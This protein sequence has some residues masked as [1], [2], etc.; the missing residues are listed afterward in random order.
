MKLMSDAIEII[1]LE[2]KATHLIFRCCLFCS[3]YRYCKDLWPQSL[4]YFDECVSFYIRS[5]FGNSGLLELVE[6]LLEDFLVAIDDSGCAAWV[7]DK[8]LVRVNR[9]YESI[10]ENLSYL[11]H[12]RIQLQRHNHFCPCKF[13]HFLIRV[14][15]KFANSRKFHNFKPHNTFL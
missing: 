2:I 6:L 9:T 1:I 7:D 5:N 10:Y 3:F 12:F 15:Y 14:I 4:F 13:N 11:S 8:M